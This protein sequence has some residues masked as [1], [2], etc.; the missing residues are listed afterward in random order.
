MLSSDRSL[1]KILIVDDEP[2]ILEFVG[3]NLQREGYQIAQAENGHDAVTLA[4]EIEPHLILLDI[5]MPEMDGVTTCH[6]IRQETACKDTV[7]AFLTARHEEYS[8]IAG[9]DAGADDYIRKP[10]SPSVLKS[11]VGALLR[12]YKHLGVDVESRREHL[13]L[14][15]DQEKFEARIGSE[16]LDLA[17]KEFEILWLMTEKPGKVYS[18][19]E[20][21]RHVWGSDVIVGNRTID[22]HVSKLRQK[23]GQRFI[24]TVKGIGYK[25][26][27]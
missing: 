7:I 6:K 12:R 19:E 22:V 23:L 15:L 8:E 5:M 13:D 2:D 14:A 16:R 21:Y 18:R 4:S 26:E 3:Y 25:L 20:I 1:Y 10:V 17:K 27:D 11:R 24:K 9:F